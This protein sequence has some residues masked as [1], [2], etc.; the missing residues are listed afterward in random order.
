MDRRLLDKAFVVGTS[1]PVRPVRTVKVRAGVWV[2]DWRAERE[3]VVLGVADGIVELADRPRA[4]GGL[5]AG[6]GAVR[7]W[8]ASGKPHRSSRQ[9]E[10]HSRR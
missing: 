2:H 6:R 8:N 9:F 5:G 10:R 1:R 7:N 3:R 4:L